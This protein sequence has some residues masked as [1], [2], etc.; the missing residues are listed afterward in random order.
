MNKNSDTPDRAKTGEYMFD[1]EQDVALNALCEQLQKIRQQ[2]E[3]AGLYIDDRELLA[4][5]HCGLQEDVLI[6]GRLVTHQA[7]AADATDS[8]LRFA[9]AEDGGFVCPQC[10]AMIAGDFFA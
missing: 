3:N 8:G 7:D 1:P 4:C 10:G 9:A 5:T 6:D 2:A